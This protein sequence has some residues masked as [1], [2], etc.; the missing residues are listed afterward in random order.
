MKIYLDVCCYNRPFDDLSNDRNRF[1]SEAICIILERCEKGIYEIISGDI[2]EYEIIR[3]PNKDKQDS[4]MRLLGISKNKAKLN[5]KIIDR[6]KE[7]EEFKIKPFDALHLASAEF[8][9]IKC[10]LTTDD[11]LIKKAT[12][13]DF[14]FKVTN[15]ID[16]LHGEIFNE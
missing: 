13:V 14:T 15:P 7:I 8:S 9:G 6:A 3:M 4:V 1:E 12:K 16:F 2:I 5:N 10:F 11:A